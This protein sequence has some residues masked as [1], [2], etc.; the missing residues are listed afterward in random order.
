MRPPHDQPRTNFVLTPA[1]RIRWRPHLL[2][3]ISATPAAAAAQ[4]RYDAVHKGGTY[5]VSIS[6]HDGRGGIDAKKFTLDV[7]D[8]LVN[9][10]QQGASV[11]TNNS[12]ARSMP[13]KIRRC[14]RREHRADLA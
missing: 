3:W 14:R 9:W 1:P 6:A 4:L 5:S 8:P 12:T 11:T 13:R 10:T 7:A 2:R